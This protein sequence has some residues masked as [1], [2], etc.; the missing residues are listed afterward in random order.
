MNDITLGGCSASSLCSY[1]KAL[2]ILRLV[3]DQL[4]NTVRGYWNGNAFM[5]KTKHSRDDLTRYFL[6]KYSPSP[7]ISPWNGRAGFLEGDDGDESTRKGA[8]TISRVE[9]SC[10]S[11][12]SL[13]RNIIAAVRNVS[14]VT[15]LD[16]T[17]AEFKALEKK[18][19]TI[20]LDPSEEGQLKDLKK[21]REELKDSLLL[22]LRGE[23]PDAFLPWIDACF[24]LTTSEGT[25]APLLGSGGNEGSMDFSINHVSYLLDLIDENSDE[26][27]PL[28]KSTLFNA[29]YGDT[30]PITSSSNIGFLDASSTGG[31]NMT[32][33]FAGKSNGNTWSCIL[34]IEGA[35]LFASSTT[36][37]LESTDSGK[38]SFPFAVLPAYAGNGSIA[39]K[40]SA[41]PEL[42]LPT[43]STP[44]PITE[45]SRLF[46]EGRVTLDGYNVASGVDML[47]ALS[48][49]GIDR[50]I[51]AFERYGIYER[52]GQGTFV[53]THIG[54]YAMRSMQSKNWVLSDLR[55]ANWLQSFRNYSQ[56]KNVASRFLMLR[57]QLED[58]LFDLSGREPSAT[59]VQAILELLGK[60]QSALA[61]SSK[62]RGAVDPLPRLE[63]WA[64][65][66]D[67][68]TPA[69]RIAR[70]LAGLH[71]NNGLPL[72]LQA[73]L[74]PVHPRYNNK[75]I[76]DAGNAGKDPASRLRF[77]TGTAG[78]LPHILRNLLERRLWLAQ[79]L[80]MKGK[81]LD[82]PS[83]ATLSDVAAF[84]QNDSMDRRIAALLP[85]L[86]L[87]SIPEEED[88]S[89]GEGSLSS[90]F[91][92]LKLCFSPD[93]I[94][95][96][97]HLIER[98]KPLPVPPG[99]IAQLAS[100]YD[101]KR[102][103]L[104]AWRRLH[105]SGLKPVFSHNA[106]PTLAGI[107][108]QR[109]AAAL[110]IPLRY[111]AYARLGHSVL[112]K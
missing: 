93:A 32:S 45:L 66:A 91:A 55:K 95:S 19:K 5:I 62:A 104:A 68:G 47:Q 87:C 15:R 48:L 42:W 4:D 74:Y 13:Y 60:I 22:S 40:E 58:R 108:P 33:G 109:A 61:G 73:Q 64:I 35:V 28:A 43:W 59:E 112:K 85:G 84:L 24:T 77:C 69:F 89:S 98:G 9:H 25:P 96:S 52:R 6:S 56:G 99:T 92:L 81:P 82:S 37:R 34:A 78:S 10:G 80:E 8:V 76:D 16:E 31:L 110:L 18:K 41:R 38:P 67:D 54:H 3:T 53:A 7:I 63:R 65:A 97:L 111:G 57:K 26:P 103:V 107:S 105:A 30:Q 14:A 70:A 23:L 27:T 88:R 71:G 50:G 29:L 100:G 101:P 86:S 106:L 72:P 36:K 17:R 2:G 90:A 102:T 94:L 20:G 49:L 1:L 39:A 83:G 75:W 51:A 21:Q 46:S 79:K 44:A 11:R 12:F